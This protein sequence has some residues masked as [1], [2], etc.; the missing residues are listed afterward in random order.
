MSERIFIGVAWPYA[1]GPI[2]LGHA[3]G[4]YI[5][6]DI[7]A[8]Y[9]RTKGNEVLMVSGSD[10][11]GTPI[12]LKA[13]QEGKTPEQIATHYHQQFVETFQKLGIT[14][15]LFT[16]THTPIILKSPRIFS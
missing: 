3:A 15:D 8:R 2:H 4:A 7:F 13:D 1:S 6:A 16:S 11:H 12:T 9:H 14:F 5:P 10:M